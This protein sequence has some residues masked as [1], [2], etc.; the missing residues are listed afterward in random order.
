MIGEGNKP[1]ENVN[2][3]DVMSKLDYNNKLAYVT[4]V[5]HRLVNYHLIE[6]FFGVFILIIGMTLLIRKRSKL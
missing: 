6:V 3:K 5:Y 2:L 1:I 4:A